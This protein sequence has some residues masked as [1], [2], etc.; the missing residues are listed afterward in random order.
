M[1][2]M[3]PMS[4]TLVIVVSVSGLKGGSS[5]KYNKLLEKNLIRHNVD[6]DHRTAYFATTKEESAAALAASEKKSKQFMAHA[7]SHCRRIKSGRIPFSSDSVIWLKRREAYNKLLKYHAG[8]N[9]NR[10]NLKRKC[11]KLRIGS[12]FKLSVV[13]IAAR[14][15]ACDSKC[16]HFRKHGQRY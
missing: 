13:E 9:V 4:V 1:L 7:E 2:L 16:D 3:L 6:E 15:K 12:P 5:Q 10:G 11:R 8:K 14:L